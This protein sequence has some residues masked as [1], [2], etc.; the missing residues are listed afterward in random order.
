MNR[1]LFDG[2]SVAG[3]VIC[4]TAVA[5]LL[6]R[7]NYGALVMLYFVWGVACAAMVA[8]V[9]L[10][11]KVRQ[12]FQSICSGGSPLLGLRMILSV[13]LLVL[14]WYIN[15]ASEALYGTDSA[16]VDNNGVR[17]F[18]VIFTAVFHVIYFAFTK[19]KKE[20]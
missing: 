13:A 8:I 19:K 4:A 11:P 18:C 17:M 3:L 7:W 20:L 12:Q 14:G 1:S 5:D 6:A 15:A 16:M 10:S 2:I 9:L